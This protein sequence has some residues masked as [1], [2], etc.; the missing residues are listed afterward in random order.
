M[1]QLLVTDKHILP[2]LLLIADNIRLDHLVTTNSTYPHKLFYII[3]RIWP[4]LR[5][6]STPGF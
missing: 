1:G 5:R 3:N 4:G 6:F 2:D